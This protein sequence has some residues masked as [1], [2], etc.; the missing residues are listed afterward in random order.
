MFEFVKSIINKFTFVFNKE[1]A[2]ISF[3]KNRIFEDS[4]FTYKDNPFDVQEFLQ[5]KN[6]LFAKFKID[7]KYASDII[8]KVCKALDVNPQ[9]ILISLEREQ[10]LITTRYKIENGILYVKRIYEKTW[11]RGEKVLNRALNVGMINEVNSFNMCNFDKQ[12]HG[13][14]GVYRK[15]FDKAGNKVGKLFNC[16]DDSDIKPENAFTY[17]LYQYCPW[18]G[19][20]DFYQT[21]PVKD[22]TGK[23][24]NT[25]KILLHK[26]PFGNFFTWVIYQRWWGKWNELIEIQLKYK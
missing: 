6:T 7:G 23:I 24:V 5:R 21:R 11:V 10:N 16:S 8:I 4:F 1:S 2:K 26:K 9:L 20:K 19:S 18:Q 15:W 3:N 17:S 12:I 25:Q 13:C 14:T 22:E